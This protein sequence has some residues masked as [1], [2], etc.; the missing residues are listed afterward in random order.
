VLVACGVGEGE[1]EI[2]YRFKLVAEGEDDA[3]LEL[4]FFFL[5][6]DPELESGFAMQEGFQASSSVCC[7]NHTGFKSENLLLIQSMGF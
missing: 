6:F 3:E 5:F 4:E 7:L 2:W 1:G